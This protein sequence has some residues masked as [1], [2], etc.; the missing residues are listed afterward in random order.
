M[1]TK[2]QYNEDLQLLQEFKKEFTE[3]VKSMDLIE[4]EFEIDNNPVV[5]PSQ[6]YQIKVNVK[7]CVIRGG[8]FKKVNCRNIRAYLY[9]STDINPNGIDSTGRIGR[10]WTID[11]DVIAD[12]RYY[13]CRRINQGDQFFGKYFYAESSAKV[14]EKFLA[15]MN[16]WKTA[17]KKIL[18]K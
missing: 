15:D 14:I 7:N 5:Y 2:K 9:L 10:T 13:R 12:T 3:K 1:Y 17:Y 11:F 8:K 16:E 4:S 18:L 6:Q